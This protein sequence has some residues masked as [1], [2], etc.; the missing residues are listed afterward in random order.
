MDNLTSQQEIFAQGIADNLS[1]A[2]A[3][4]KAYPK[5]QQWKPES[6]WSHASTL[7]ANSKVRER[8]RKLKEALAEKQLWTREESVEELKKVLSDVDARPSDKTAAVKVLND[9]HGFNAPQKIEHSGPNGGVIPHSMV[10]NIVGFSESAM[11][12]TGFLDADED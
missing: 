4:R 6:V 7:M 2:D 11:M 3:Y 8:V 10:I 1:Q 5:S 12:Q 9:M